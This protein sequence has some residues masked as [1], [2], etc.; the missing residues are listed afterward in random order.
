[1]GGKKGK[2]ILETV[3]GARSNHDHGKAGGRGAHQKKSPKKSS[4]GAFGFLQLR[5]VSRPGTH[6]RERG[7]RGGEDRCREV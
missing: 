2:K 5:K 3:D 7:S 4:L 1:M 6:N